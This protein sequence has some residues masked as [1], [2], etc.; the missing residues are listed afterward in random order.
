M[1]LTPSSHKLKS[2]NEHSYYNGTGLTSVDL[3]IIS[4]YIRGERM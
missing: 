1:V 2:T 3:R 4:E